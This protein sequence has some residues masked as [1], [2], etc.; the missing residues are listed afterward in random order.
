MGECGNTL[1]RNPID[2]TAPSASRPVT[3]G[4]VTLGIPDAPVVDT[5]G[6]A[7]RLAPGNGIALAGPI[8]PSCPRLAQLCGTESPPSDAAWPRL[9]EAPAPPNPPRCPALP[10]PAPSGAR[11]PRPP[12]GP[13]PP[14]SVSSSAP[15]KSRPTPIRSRPTPPPSR[16]TRPTPSISRPTVSSIRPSDSV[17]PNAP[18]SPDSAPPPTSAVLLAPL[19]APLPDAPVRAVRALAGAEAADV[20]AD[21]PV[22]I[23]ICDMP[24]PDP[25][26]DAR[27]C[28]VC[29]TADSD[30]VMV[31]AWVPAE[32]PADWATAAD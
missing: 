12:S 19:M 16:P 26:G 14:D 9:A 32:L 29:G 24:D 20:A 22:P 13:S 18:A 17:P 5:A 7:P 1:D 6:A 21:V 28:N 4:K 3:L 31:W 15:R 2:L 10:S 27:L 23:T 8:D 11:P 25:A 30:D